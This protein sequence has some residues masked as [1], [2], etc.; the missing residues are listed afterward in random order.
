M[1][2]PI[3]L[4]YIDDD[5]A[6]GRLLQKQLDRL[7][8]EIKHVADGASGLEA[9]RQGGISAVVLDHYMPGQ[10]GLQTLAAIR[11]LPDPPPVIYATGTNDGKVA[12]AALKAGAADYV[13]KDLTGEFP[14]LLQAAVEAALESVRLRRAKLGEVDRRAKSRKEPELA[15]LVVR[16]SDKIPGAGWWVEKNDRKYSG[17]WD[18]PEAYAY[19]RKIQEKAFAY[20]K[21]RQ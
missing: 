13:V 21:K 3:K 14:L 1:P 17:P 16:A 18:G 6:L 19:I 15:V 4:L 20:W 10:D 8:Y 11:A 2:S 5:V 9:I 12:V 7:G